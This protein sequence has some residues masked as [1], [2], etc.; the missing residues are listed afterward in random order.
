MTESILDQLEG[1][2]QRSVRLALPKTERALQ[3]FLL[4]AL[5]LQHVT[6]L[7]VTPTSVSVERFI[8]PDGEVLTPALKAVHAGTALEP[9]IETLV[10]VLKLDALVFNPE[11]HILHLL[12]RLFEM[13]HEQQMQPVALF[14]RR[15]D[16]LPAALGLPSGVAPKELFG[17]PV[18]YVDTTLEEGSV[19][20]V[21]SSSPFLADATYGVAAD[22]GGVT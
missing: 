13:V 10:Q 18:T 2:V 8:E 14:A 21:G 22:I 15:G 12:M 1:K 9:D 3:Q 7:Q 16:D 19:L 6:S 5:H 20:L 17:V 4:G 11:G